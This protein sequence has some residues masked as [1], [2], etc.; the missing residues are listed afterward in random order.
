M[1]ERHLLR[2]QIVDIIIAQDLQ[3]NPERVIQ[4]IPRN[5]NLT[6]LT[7]HREIRLLGRLILQASNCHVNRLVPIH[8]LVTLLIRIQILQLGT[9]VNQKLLLAIT[10][11]ASQ[12]SDEATNALKDTLVSFSA[13]Q[14]CHESL[15]LW[16]W[17]WRLLLNLLFSFLTLSLLFLE[18]LGSHF[19]SAPGD[20]VQVAYRI[21]DK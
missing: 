16:R 13:Q 14:L 17:L 12:T 1:P 18:S 6:A 3:I 19:T 9:D 7:L 5:L 21:D 10:L 20:N 11:G 15:W 2:I 8:S 4:I